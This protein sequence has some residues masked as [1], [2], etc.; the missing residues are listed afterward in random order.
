MAAAEFKAKGNAALKAG[1]LDEAIEMYTEAIAL[2]G[3]DHVFYSNRSA[4]Y[5]KK[6]DSEKAFEDGKKCVELNEHW[7]K[8]YNRQ[9][10]ALHTMKKYD[11]AEDIFMAGL[12][13]C[14]G[15]KTL[16]DGLNEVKKARPNSNPFGN[17]MAKLATHPKF[18]QWVSDPQ[19]MA[20]INMMQQN[21]QMIV[22]M[23]QDPS[24]GEVMQ[25]A[26]G[27]STAGFPGA[28][29]SPAA[30]S[31]SQQ[32]AEPM[33][34][35]P[36]APVELNE[37][38]QKAEDVKAIRARG[39]DHYK[40]KELDEALACYQ[41]V[42]EKDPSQ[43]SVLNNISAVYMERKDWAAAEKQ[44]AEAVEAAQKLR[45]T[46]FDVIAKIYV[47]WGNIYKNQKDLAKAIEYFE[48][49]QMENS[50]RE[51]E[52]L[53]KITSLAKK[54]KDKQD[55]IN[56]ELGE[57]AKARGNDAYRAK[58]WGK[59]IEE[60]EDA[61][62]RDPTNPVYRNNLASTLRSVMDF[63]GAK[64][65]CEKALE[66]D[67]N[68][69]KAWAQKGAIECLQKEYHK[70]M[71]SYQEGLKIEPENEACK[72]GYNKVMY[73]I[74]SISSNG[75]VDKER[76]AHGMADPEIQMILSDPIVR[77]VIQDLGGNDAAA[78]QKAMADPVMKAKIHKLIAAGVLQ[79]R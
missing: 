10:A 51:V 76:A 53:I 48:K 56:P 20:K 44:C 58:E 47:R 57:A 14:P 59:A 16:Q 13:K 37:E 52:R 35:E 18:S 15:D 70:A 46:P 21:P 78:G 36:P 17:I 22:Q 34:V 25:A 73:Q 50:T 79:T 12:E 5:L 6:G 9:G 67:P 8:G 38:E 30:P 65:N 45:P 23:M 7:A 41:E 27:I 1:N 28:D 75:E 40:K 68:Y 72:T 29:D 42:Y 77:Q 74:N 19:M 4:A 61:I 69:V 63:Q 31:E 39:N 66:L 62:K 55:Y 11:E 26:F 64:S 33:D 3:S 60:Y 49:A 54:K 32:A 2:D 43:V 71:E 24:M